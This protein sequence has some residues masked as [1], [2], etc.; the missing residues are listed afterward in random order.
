[1]KKTQ[2][3]D[4]VYIILGVLLIFS[5][6]G[7]SPNSASVVEISKVELKTVSPL[8]MGT[9]PTSFAEQIQESIQLSVIPTYTPIPPSVTPKPTSTPTPRP[10]NTPTS[11]STNTPLPANTPTL[12]PP[13]PVLISGSC[14]SVDYESY[15][16]GSIAGS[17]AQRSAAGDPDV[18]LELHGYNVVAEKAELI[19]YPVHSNQDQDAPQLK[20]LFADR[21]IPRFTVTYN[22]RGW[23]WD[24]FTPG[25]GLREQWPVTVLGLGVSSG[26]PIL[27]PDV[28]NQIGGGYKVMVLYADENQISVKYG[29]NDGV[30]GG[31]VIQLDGLCVEP[32]LLALYR[33]T[34]Q[35][36]RLELPLLRAGQAVGR[37]STTSLRV[38]IRYFGQFMDPRSKDDWW[39]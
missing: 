11:R 20:G 19:V 28:G 29:R 24:S 1:M 7:C 25:N 35:K 9:P 2:L 33:D 37:A 26:E 30:S 6:V 31:Y 39:R 18:N 32:N 38:A 10:S 16:K 8:E 5:G 17:P 21:R 23:N 36:G 4:L 15:N 22:A 27:V 14:G 13:T 12:M 3:R 34:N